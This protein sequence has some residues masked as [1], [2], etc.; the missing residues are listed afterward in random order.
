MDRLAVAKLHFNAVDDAH[1]IYRQ[2]LRIKRNLLGLYHADV[3]HIS[4]Q[5][6]RI[7]F[8]SGEVLS[9]QASF[10][11]ALFVYRH[12]TCTT[13]CST[14]TMKAADALCSI[15][16]IKLAQKKYSRSVGYFADALKVRSVMHW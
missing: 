6:G 14:W 16:S 5:L 1:D 11:D 4:T 10:E 2:A 13:G 3:A 8:Y 12:L 7:Y 15:G 9:A